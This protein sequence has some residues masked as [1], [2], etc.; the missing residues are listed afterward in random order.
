[1]AR[2]WCTTNPATMSVAS[3]RKLTPT[4]TGPAGDEPPAA[5][6]R[7][8]TGLTVFAFG[9]LAVCGGVA[10]SGLTSVPTG[11]TLPSAANPQFSS[12]VA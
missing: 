6:G 3:T 7:L 11:L 12:L 4:T 1:M 9:F 5:T 10:G 8:A 2:R